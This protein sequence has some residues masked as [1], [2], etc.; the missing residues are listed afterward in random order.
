MKKI[1]G[2]TVYSNFTFEKLINELCTKGNQKLYALVWCAKYISTDKRRTWFK[3]FAV[4]QFSYIPLVWVSH[5]R[6]SNNVIN[7]LHKN[8][9]R[10][11]YQ[12]RNSSLDE[13][14]KLGKSSPESILCRNFQYYLTELYKVKMRLSQPIMNCILTLN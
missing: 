13:L 5:K 14:L 6:E 10:L 1:I 8:T 2:V 9:L 7:S 4:S 12:N 3:A 11:T